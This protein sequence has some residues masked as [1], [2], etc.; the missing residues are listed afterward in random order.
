MI[1]LL[2]CN[3]DTALEEKKKNKR[4]LNSYETI[5]AMPS[6]SSKAYCRHQQLQGVLCQLAAAQAS[7]FSM[8]QE[9]DDALL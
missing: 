4:L 5:S 3:L 8:V 2:P 1:P 6:A 9:G 7:T